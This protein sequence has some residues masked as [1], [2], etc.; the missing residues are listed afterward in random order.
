MG[1]GAEALRILPVEQSDFTGPAAKIA[2]V[3]Q[4][5]QAGAEAVQRAGEALG[6]QAG[7]GDQQMLARGQGSDEPPGQ[8]NPGGVVTVEFIA[9][10]QDG[11]P[12]GGVSRC[13]GRCQQTA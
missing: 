8:L 10:P 1:G 11:N 4:E 3:G 2:G 6:G 5:H 12:R 13:P 9:N 7:F